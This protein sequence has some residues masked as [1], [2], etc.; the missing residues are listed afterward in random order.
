[1]DSVDFKAIQEA[2]LGIDGILNVRVVGENSE[3]A[4]IHVLSNRSKAPKLLVRDIETL[5]NARFGVEIDHRKISIVSFDVEDSSKEKSTVFERPV[6]WSIGWK[7]SLGNLQIQIEIKLG[8]KIFPS[9]VS[10]SIWNHRDR[11]YMIAH[12]VIECM[13]QITGI[14]FFVLREVCVQ[15]H[16]EFEVALALV[17]YRNSLKDEEILVG[18]AL[19]KED[20]YESVARATLDAINRKIFCHFSSLPD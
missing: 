7:K 3:I 11:H 14:P 6:L 1:M 10:E 8:G 16:G 4:E 9:T 20:V 17:D 18:T 12:A 15:K 2:I 13:H 5:I 19:V